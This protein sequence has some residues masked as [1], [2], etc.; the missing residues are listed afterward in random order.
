M[1]ET[2]SVPRPSGRELVAI[3]A[4]C[5]L[6]GVFVY[7][8]LRKALHPVDFLKL[9][10]QYEMGDSPVLLNGIAVVLPWIEVLCGLFLLAGIAVRGSALMSLAMLV[11]FSLIVLQRA[12]TLH[13]TNAIPFCAV[14]FDCGCGAGEVIIC[15]KLLENIVLVLLSLWLLTVRANRWCVR[16]ALVNSS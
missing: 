1:N 15:Y 7:L 3:V 4:R 14:R 2:L 12:W 5:I 11:P 10:R 8:G 9:L 16:Y 13:E 6:G